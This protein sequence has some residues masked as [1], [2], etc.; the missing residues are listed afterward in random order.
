MDFND[1]LSTYMYRGDCALGYPVFE[2]Y[3]NNG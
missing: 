2:D 3:S 1:L